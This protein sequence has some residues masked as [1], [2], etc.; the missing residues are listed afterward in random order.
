VNIRPATLDDIPSVMSLDRESATAAHWTEGRYRQAFKREG[1]E[2]LLLVAEAS[3]SN[4]TG[5]DVNAG[6]LG[7]LVASHVAP[8]WE[9]ENIAVASSAR[10]K[11]IGKRLLSALLAAA[12]E[13][14][15]DSVFLEVR[16]SNAAARTLYEKAGFEQTGRRKSYYSDPVEDAVLYRMTLN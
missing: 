9:L 12:R 13:T 15:S 6:I 10:R 16:E 14:N 2:R 5:R 1:L 8:E 11:G 4:Q 7:F 3:P